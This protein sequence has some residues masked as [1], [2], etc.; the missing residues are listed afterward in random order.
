MALGYR[1]YNG[2]GVNAN[3]DA[4]LTWYKR[5]GQK[6]ADK[7]KL[8]G[9]PS[10]QR[11]RIPEEFEASGGSDKLLNRNIFNYYTYL[12]GSGDIQSTVSCY[13]RTVKYK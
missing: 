2:I 10:V 11:I 3:C 9:S 7:V 5:V 6:V 1:Y 12:A 4:A 8:T 13:S